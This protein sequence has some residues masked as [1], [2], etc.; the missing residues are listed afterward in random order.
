MEK[1]NE[2]F[3]RR[4]IRVSRTEFQLDD[5]TVHPILPPLDHDPSIEEFQE[6]YDRARRAIQG[7]ADARGN[8]EDPQAMASGRK[9]KRIPNPGRSSQDI[10]GGDQEDQGRG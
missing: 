7:I 3:G 10:P 6:H 1:D 9:A 4:V 8:D 5:M 2:A